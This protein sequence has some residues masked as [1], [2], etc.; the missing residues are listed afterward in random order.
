MYPSL[1]IHFLFVII[2]HTL[3]FTS[4]STS[5]EA[6]IQAIHSSKI[7]M[8]QP[9]DLT[10][11]H[12]PINVGVILMKGETELQDIAPVDMLHGLS[13][14]FISTFPDAL[15]PPGFKDGA[16]DFNFLWITEAGEA[17]PANL[18]G[19]LRIL[20]THSFETSPTLDIVIVGAHRFGYEPSKAELAFVAKSFES[21]A[22]FIAVC[23]GV[24]IPRLAGVL[25]GKTATGPRPLLDAWRAQSPGTNW[26]D[27]RWQRDGKMWT[28]GALFNGC[29][30]VTNFVKQT[31]SGTPAGAI[32]DFAAKLGAWPD[33]DVDY[34]DVL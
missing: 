11:P 2:Q 16:I 21:C 17:E 34:K 8:A 1:P 27:K 22:A 6:F 33:R 4:I 32:G 7:A 25:E 9:L 31:W 15:G 5:I 20:P 3:V 19:G 29:D 10:K 13:R 30:L 12:R 28:S 14:H 23:G 24:D 18:T 26:V